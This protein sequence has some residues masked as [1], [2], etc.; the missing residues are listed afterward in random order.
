MLNNILAK[1][2]TKWKTSVLNIFL[3]LVFFPVLRD[4]PVLKD[5]VC[6]PRT[7]STVNQAINS[8]VAFTPCLHRNSVLVSGESSGIFQVFPEYTQSFG[9]VDS[10][11]HVHGLLD[12]SKYVR[13]PN[14]ILFSRISF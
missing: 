5:F 2:I 6:K 1:G 13:A 4:F 10:S 14:D 12:S 3:E 8:I 7:S 9:H 11:V